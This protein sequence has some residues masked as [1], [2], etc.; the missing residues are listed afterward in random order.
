MCS[1]SVGRCVLALSIAFGSAFAALPACADPPAWAGIW[2]LRERYHQPHDDDT[3]DYRVVYAPQPRVASADMDSAV[4]P[5]AAPVA[6]GLA[7][8]FNRGTCDRGLVM[9]QEKAPLTGPVARAMDGLDRACVV[10]AL[11]ILPDGRSIA[12]AGDA[13][14]IFRVRTERSYPLAKRT[15]RDYTATALIDEQKRLFS[16][17]A[18]RRTDGRWELV[19]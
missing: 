8:G 11:R 14:T 4:T 13:G 12:W 9:S 6:R 3:D 15:C 18:C 7:F 19:G 10:T 5:I 1:A 2:Q 16:A 17:T